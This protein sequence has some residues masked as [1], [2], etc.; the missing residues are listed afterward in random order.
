[1]FEGG[2]RVPMCMR[3]PSKIKAGGKI[4][5]PVISLDFLPTFVAAAGGEVDDAW[6][7]DGVNLLPRLTGAVAELEERLLFW[8]Q[9]QK[10]AVRW[11]N[12]KLHIADVADESTRNVYDLS[13]DVGET[14]PLEDFSDTERHLL[15]RALTKWDAEMVAAKWGGSASARK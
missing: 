11:G 6:Q 1:L 14:T 9:G 10:R 3:W 5:D 13:Q 2:I 15:Y 7:L 8:R 12:Y 4:D